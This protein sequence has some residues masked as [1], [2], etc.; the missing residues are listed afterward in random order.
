[1]S[2]G[3]RALGIGLLAGGAGISLLLILW[4]L[5][6]G[7]NAGGF[8]LGLLLIL[9]LGG[10]LAGAGWY[11][12]SRAPAEQQQ[13]LAFSRKQRIL[14]SDRVF[15]AQTA[16]ALRNIGETPALPT[17]DLRA[18]ADELQD[19][20]HTTA[21]WQD[22]VQLDD[23]GIE[24]LRRYD[25]LVRERV[26]RLRDQPTN[27]SQALR[28]LRQ[29]IDQREDLLLHGRVAAEVAPTALLTTDARPA[30]GPGLDQIGLGDAISREGMNFLVE[31]LAT[32][33]AEGHRWKMARLVPTSS[34]AGAQWLYVGPGALDLALL[35]ETTTP[36]SLPLVASGTAVADVQDRTHSAQGILVSYQRYRSDPHFAVVERWPDAADRVLAGDLVNSSDLEYW[37][38]AARASL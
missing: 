2:S 8:V 18:L 35:E 10:P 22:L 17:T 14:D 6:S 38:A 26:R 3:S 29:S 34:Q 7:V 28:E 31:N 1:V 4:L 27:P 24:T 30:I 20:T 32:Y 12:L 36:P 25:D 33:F 19:T 13:A 16:A 5:V 21:A 11:L 15:R 9:V 37:P 23:S